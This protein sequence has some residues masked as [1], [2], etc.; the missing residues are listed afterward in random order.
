MRIHR[1]RKRGPQ[2]D[3]EINYRTNEDI[4]AKKVRV[5][6]NEGN[7]LDVMPTKKALEVARERGFDLVEVSPKAKP[8]VCKLLDYGQFKYR[9]QKELRKQKAQSK[10]VEIKG[11]RLS[12][13]IGEHDLKVRLSQA[14]KFLKEGNKAKI[15]LVLRG[16]EK[17]HKDRAREV[18]QSFIDR[19]RD[20]FDIRV[21]Q[22]IE[23][24]SGRMTAIV[25]RE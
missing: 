15:E 10:E 25:G 22:D 17:A 23:Y 4:S 21:E 2:N 13:N 6:D 12:L 3:N 20:N 16:R 1:H 14:E 11:V 5:I 24:Q 8:P 18:I 7:M 9:K 19:L